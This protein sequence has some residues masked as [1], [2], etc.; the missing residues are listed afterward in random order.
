MMKTSISREAQKNHGSKKEQGDL[1][2]R[3]LNQ[4]KIVY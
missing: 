1:K 3:C 4:D 2:S